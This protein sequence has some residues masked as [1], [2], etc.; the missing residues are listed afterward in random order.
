VK[1][2]SCPLPVLLLACLS[3]S[4]T[5]QAPAARGVVTAIPPFRDTLE[6]R[7]YCTRAGSLVLHFNAQSAWGMFEVRVA[8]EPFQGLIVAKWSNGLLDGR[9]HDRSGGGRIVLSFNAD[10]T[11]FIGAFATDKSGPN[12][13]GRWQG[14]QARTATA[15]VSAVGPCRGAEPA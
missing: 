5:A 6:T 8:G 1:R 11:G 12:W 3:A 9:Y 15:D 2:G 13:I 10:R 7:A 4:A 14:K